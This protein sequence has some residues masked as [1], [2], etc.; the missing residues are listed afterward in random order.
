MSITIELQ[1]DPDWFDLV[2]EVRAY[3][4]LRRIANGNPEDGDYEAADVDPADWTPDAKGYITGD[5]VEL[6]EAADEVASSVME[7]LSGLL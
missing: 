4:A 2:A 3:H 7:A 1:I 5:D 6:F